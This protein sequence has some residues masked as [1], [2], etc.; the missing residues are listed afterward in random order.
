MP[1][2]YSEVLSSAS[3]G[4]TQS[5]YPRNTTNAQRKSR[6]KEITWSCTKFLAALLCAFCLST[7]LILAGLV[8]LGYVSFIGGLFCAVWIYSKE[9][10]PVLHKDELE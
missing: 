9:I 1:K 3:A 4:R 6:I 5:K 8:V 10:F 2:S 7:L